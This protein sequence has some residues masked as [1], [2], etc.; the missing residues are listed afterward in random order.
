VVLAGCTKPQDGG[1][2]GSGG[3]S[4]GGGGK[5]TVTVRGSDTMLQL[6]QAW[7]EDFGKSHPGIVINVNGGGS[8]TGIKALINHMADIA[9][10]SRS[11]EEKEKESIT[12]AGAEPKEFTVAQDA[13]S[14]IVHPSNLVNELTMAQLKD[15]YTGK[16]ANWKQ[17]GGP[18]LKITLNS[19][20]SSS[21]TYKFFQEHVMNKEPYADVAQLQPS[22]N[23]I[24]QNVSQDKG[25]I[26]YV[27]LGY[28]NDKVK[29]IKVKKDAASPGVAA[30]VEDVL[31]KTYPLSRP[32]FMYTAGEP[33]AGAKTFID[34]VQGP[35]GQAIV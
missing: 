23:G 8:G 22:T 10:A 29:A 6:A 13:L 3:T 11:I 9:N 1:A 21:G 35:D 19:R 20:D 12:K 27:G 7:A 18:D 28:V 15:I 31:N 26:G 34:W 32:L 24:V 4:G 30:N 5:S 17:V 2:T 14:V 16:A 25:G 33:T